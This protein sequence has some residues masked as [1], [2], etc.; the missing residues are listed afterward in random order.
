MNSAQLVAKGVDP[1]KMTVVYRA[2]EQYL[3][4]VKDP[5]RFTVLFAGNGFYRKGGVELLKAFQQLGRDDVQL[6][7]V[8]SLEVDW[9]VFPSKETIEW[10]R[11][12]IAGD[13]RITVFPQMSHDA[14]TQLMRKAHVFVSTTFSDPFNNTILEAMG[15]QLPVICSDISSLPE[16]VQHGRNGVHV[17]VT[18]RPSD[19]IAVEIA[20]HL[21]R[22]M[23]DPSELE[24]LAGAS[25]GIVRERFDLRVRNRRL[26]EIYDGA[27]A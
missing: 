24:R 3:P 27:L 18:D 5:S 11:S 6:W 16:I 12:T 2:V 9:G 19:D 7:I 10:T 26:L 15:C 20:M 17:P 1:A 13:P 25:L 8:S 4:G 14:L 22:L 23:D 21:R